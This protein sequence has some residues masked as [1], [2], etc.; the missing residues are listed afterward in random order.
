[1]D[2]KVPAITNVGDSVHIF[3]FRKSVK[4]MREVFDSI[5]A[6]STQQSRV[7]GLMKHRLFLAVLTLL[8]TLFACK[9]TGARWGQL[10]SQT[11]KNLSTAMHGEAFAYEK[12]SLYASQARRNGNTELAR[13]FEDAAST[14]RLEH[15]AEEAH[16]A[17]LV[18][19]DAENLKDAIEG[20]SYE[21]DTMYRE[22]AK[23]AAALGD[24]VAADRFEEIRHDEANHR[25]AFKAALAK[26]G[27]TTTVAH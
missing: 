23:E 12:Y 20:E 9:H 4:S 21:A 3:V 22:F 10:S 27:S 17:G 25:D 13:V 5:A 24:N 14:E 7:G 15:F 26:L 2:S 8:V 6:R 19:S 1:M 11:K 18:K 16:V